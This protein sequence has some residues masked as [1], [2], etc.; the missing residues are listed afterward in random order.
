MRRADGPECPSCGCNAAKLIAVGERNSR[1]FA[2]FQCDHC[3]SA[4]LVNAP[5]VPMRY[6]DVRSVCPHCGVVNPP[7]THTQGRVRY[8]RCKVCKLTSKSVK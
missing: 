6:N 3:Q 8:H 4:F 2:T 5:K 1:P 7:V